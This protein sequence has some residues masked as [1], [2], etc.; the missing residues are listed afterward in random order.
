MK[1]PEVGQVYMVREGVGGSLRGCVY[2]ILS[3]KHTDGYDF[4][5]TVDILEDP[6]LSLEKYMRWWIDDDKHI[7]Y[8]DSPLYQVLIGAK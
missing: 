7:P 2:R 4:F 8:Y 1:K 5:C 3:I 6:T